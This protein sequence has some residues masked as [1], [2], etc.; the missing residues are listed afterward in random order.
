MPDHTRLAA[1]A[2]HDVTCD[3]GPKCPNRKEHAAAEAHATTGTLDRFL[4]RYEQLRREPELADT[5]PCGHLA[6][7][8]FGRHGSAQRFGLMVGAGGYVAQQKWEPCDAE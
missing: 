4:D 7:G 5:L 2:W 6:H 1:T 8:H 3:D